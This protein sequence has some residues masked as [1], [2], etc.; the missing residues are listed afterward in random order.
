M[1][2]TT[3]QKIKFFGIIGHPIG[4]SLSPLLHNTA[5]KELG[6]ACK[7]E[8]FDI[9][10]TSLGAALRNFKTLDFS[11]LNVTIPYKELVRPLLDGIDEQ[12]KRIGAVNTILLKEGKAIGYNTDIHGAAKSLEPYTNELKGNHALVLGA[13]G[14]ARA[15]V[16]ALTHYFD[17]TTVTIINRS[18]QRAQNFLK[19]LRH[20]TLTRLRTFS[21]SR[22]LLK[23]A[24]EEAALIINA[25]PIGMFPNVNESPLGADIEFRKDQIVMDLIYRPLQTA[26][27]K[28]AHKA[29]ARTISGLEMFLYQGAQAFE[30]W[31]GTTMPLPKVRKV[32]EKALRT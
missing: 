28:K 14:A 4:H 15:V 8:A 12:A 9:E 6:M 24:V 5:F 26:M 7:Y 3:T 1:K 31:T 10:L 19:D 20:G 11:G 32:I 23:E 16:Y 22:P 17:L 21:S 30:L 2:T 18:Q 29:G 13:G 27:L 25:T